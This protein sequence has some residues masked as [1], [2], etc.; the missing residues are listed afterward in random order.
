[1]CTLGWT[2]IC[3]E[4]ICFSLMLYMPAFIFLNYHVACFFIHPEVKWCSR[5]TNVAFNCKGLVHQT[6]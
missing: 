3:E 2:V 4:V 1:M 5:T 6:C